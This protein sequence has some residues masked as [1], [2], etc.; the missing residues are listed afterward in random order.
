MALTV[1]RIEFGPNLKRDITK[2]VDKLAFEQKEAEVLDAC[3]TW[4]ALKVYRPMRHNNGGTFDAGFGGYRRKPK[5]PG[6]EDGQ[7]DIKK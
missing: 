4:L 1:G 2:M 6:Y 5:K 7:S 3:L